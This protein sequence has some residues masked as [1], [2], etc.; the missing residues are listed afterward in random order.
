MK[1]RITVDGRPY[2]VEVESLEVSMP[3]SAASRVEGSRVTSQPPLAQA[4]PRPSLPGARNGAAAARVEGLPPQAPPAQ[5]S[6]VEPPKPEPVPARPPW[7]GLSVGAPGECVAPVP[8]KVSRVMV[9]PGDTVRTGDA[10]VEIEVTRMMNSEDVP[11]MVGTLRA[12]EA[13]V[14][15]DVSARTGEQVAFGQVM[16]RLTPRA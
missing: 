8:G 7:H 1:M 13:G 6:P 16:V 15:T 5:S 3:G 12:I 4:G 10:L 9:K 11:V 14:V 2:E